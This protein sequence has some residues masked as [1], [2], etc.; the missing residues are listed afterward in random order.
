MLDMVLGNA[1]QALI[2]A[3]DADAAD[4]NAETTAEPSAEPDFAMPQPVGASSA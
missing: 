4:E 2:M 3:A 1:R